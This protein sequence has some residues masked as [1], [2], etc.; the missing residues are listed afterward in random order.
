[1]APNR[2]S[3]NWSDEQIAFILN[4]PLDIPSKIVAALYNARFEGASINDKSVQYIRREYKD[5][6]SWK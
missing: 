4:Q 3:K 2:V 5:N 6:R 1:M